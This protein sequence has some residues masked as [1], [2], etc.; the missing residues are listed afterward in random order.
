MEGEGRGRGH[1]ADAILQM[2]QENIARTLKRSADGFQT[3]KMGPGLNLI[4]RNGNFNPN[5]AGQD[6]C[7]NLNVTVKAE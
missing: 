2:S 6:K 4:P 7:F 3:G 1:G 5:E